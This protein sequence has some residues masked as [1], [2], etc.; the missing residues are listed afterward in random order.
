MSSRRVVSQKSASRTVVVKSIDIGRCQTSPPPVPPLP[1]WYRPRGEGRGGEGRGGEGRGGEGRGGEG[2]GGEGRGGE[3]EGRGGEGR[4]REGRGGEGRG[5]E[6]RGGEGRGGEGKSAAPRV[7]ECSVEDARVGARFAAGVVLMLSLVR[8]NC[9]RL[10]AG[11]CRSE[12]AKV[13]TDVPRAKVLRIVK[14]SK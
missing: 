6:G 3:G 2:R 11:R 13:L 14:V 8:V 4:E 7:N 12:G 10:S 5:G 9:V 1:M